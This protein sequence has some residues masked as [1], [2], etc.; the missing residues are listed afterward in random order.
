MS[1]TVKL[2]RVYQADRQIR[3]LRGRV[4]AAERFLGQHERNL[5]ELDAKRAS[6]K[7]QSRQLQATLH[8][9]EAEIAGLDERITKLREQLNAATTN[10]QYTALL[11]EVNTFKADK[12]VVEERTLESM[13]RLEE[14]AGALAE[15]EKQRAELV[16]LR[17]HAAAERDARATEIKDRLT[18]LE[19]ERAIAAADVPPD[20]MSDYE[21]ETELRDEDVMASIEE[22]D[23]K[24][25]EY[26]CSAC[27]VLLPMDV[28]STSIN[29]GTICRC[30]S[31]RAFLYIEES[32]RDAA[33]PTKR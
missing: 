24:R 15:I 19:A 10:K 8:N 9:D 28:V 22:M 4:Q 6:L 13:A 30:P 17:D 33:I 25:M 26:C 21:A 27:Q 32:T 16:K 29:G 7:A 3:G 20:V 18:E 1:I 31:C 11:T 5:A 23:R 12:A 2:L 14:V